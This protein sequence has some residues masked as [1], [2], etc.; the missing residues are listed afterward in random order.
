MTLTLVGLSGGI[1]YIIAKLVDVTQNGDT[2]KYFGSK[3][4]LT[5]FGMILQAYVVI[6][7][8]D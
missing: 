4:S 1:G 6:V 3:K 8:G 7:A 2:D 5:F